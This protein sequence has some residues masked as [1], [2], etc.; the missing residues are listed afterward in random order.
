VFSREEPLDDS[1]TA[2]GVTC[3][4]ST[5]RPAQYLP[6]SAPFAPDPSAIIR[7]SARAQ[8]GGG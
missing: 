8:G 4:R 7:E 1:P 5:R 6:R 2:V 3:L